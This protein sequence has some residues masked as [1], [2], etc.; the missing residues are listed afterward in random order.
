MLTTN[1]NC[2]EKHT[3][4][5]FSTIINL[6]EKKY[7]AGP[8]HPVKNTRIKQDN[9]E[10]KAKTRTFSAAYISFLPLMGRYCRTQSEMIHQKAPVN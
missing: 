6:M 10:G 4:Q 7:I 9:L 8:M 5:R 3:L 1:D 2:Y